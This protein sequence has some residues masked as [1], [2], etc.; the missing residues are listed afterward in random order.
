M[1]F[2][3]VTMIDVQEWDG[4][5]QET[6]GR[7]YNFQ[8]QD[9]CKERGSRQLRIPVEFPFDYENTTVPEVVNAYEMGVSFKAWL[10]RSPDKKLVKESGYDFTDLWWKRNFY[11][12]VDM[13]ANDLHS[14]G[15]LPAG[16]YAINIDW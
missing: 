6:Y 9:G 10:E 13:I 2:K 1:K 15:L 12:S 14:K 16:E 8:Q 4:L 5:V 11:P 3:Q 7:T